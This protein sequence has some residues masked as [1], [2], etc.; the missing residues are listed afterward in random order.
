[1]KPTKNHYY[2]PGCQ[3]QKMLFASKKEA[4]LFL[5]YNAD[6]IEEENGRRPV[7]AYYCRHCCGWHLTSK[8]YSHGRIDLIKRFGPEL[9][10]K[11]YD[12]ILPL[13]SRGTTVSEALTKKLKELKHNL[14]FDMING[15]KCRALIDELFDIFE[16]IIGAQLEDKTT[17]D[18]LFSK[19]SYLCNIFTTKK[20]Q[21]EIA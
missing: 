13:I 16:V 21:K 20:L 5:K 17:I 15:A 2:C 19:F 8:P 9:G 7:R 11:M 6:A 14:K 3:H 4:I 18:S 12:T 1:M 10:A